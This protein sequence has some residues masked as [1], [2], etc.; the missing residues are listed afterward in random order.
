MKQ[1]VLQRSACHPSAYGACPQE[2]RCTTPICTIIGQRNW[3]FLI[4]QA[5]ST[6]FSFMVTVT[7]ISQMGFTIFEAEQS[8]T[9]CRQPP[10]QQLHVHQTPG[11][12]ASSTLSIPT[13]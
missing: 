3:S 13:S 9:A 7:V 6:M 1:P 4:F 11:N 2:M 12:W 8:T 10:S 5:A